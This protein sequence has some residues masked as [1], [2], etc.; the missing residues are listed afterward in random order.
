[1]LIFW[2]LPNREFPWLEGNLCHVEMSSLVHVKQAICRNRPDS[3]VNI[4]RIITA[5]VQAIFQCLYS[6]ITQKIV[7]D[8]QR[9]LGPMRIIVTE[10]WFLTSTRSEQGHAKVTGSASHYTVC[11]YVVKLLVK[12]V[13]WIRISKLLFNSIKRDLIYIISRLCFLSL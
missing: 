8:C 10:W 5:A 12:K 11:N 13:I 7:R 1:M 2:P 6:W 3:G 4:V 9:L